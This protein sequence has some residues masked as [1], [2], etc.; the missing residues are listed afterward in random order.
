MGMMRFRDWTKRNS[1]TA[2]NPHMRRATLLRRRRR[3]RRRCCRRSLRRTDTRNLLRNHR[4]I[5]IHPRVLIEQCGGIGSLRSVLIPRRSLRL[6]SRIVI[7]SQ[8]E[9]A[10]NKSGC[11]SRRPYP[12][13]NSFRAFRYASLRHWHRQ[14]SALFALGIRGN[15]AQDA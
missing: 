2:K 6:C 9:V 10:D 5:G 11:T 7:R 4:Q 1:D 14:T 13:R 3:R 12:N 8:K 15:S